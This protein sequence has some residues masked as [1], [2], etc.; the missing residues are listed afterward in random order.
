M[1]NST[2]HLDSVHYSLL[3][4]NDRFTLAPKIFSP[5]DQGYFQ[6]FNGTRMIFVYFLHGELTKLAPPKRQ[7]QSL[8]A[9]GIFEFSPPVFS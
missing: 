2:V 4:C 3:Q 8:E 7:K 1:Q 5:R 9:G 6:I